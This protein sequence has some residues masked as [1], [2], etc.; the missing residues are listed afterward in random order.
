LWYRSNECFYAAT[1]QLANCTTLAACTAQRS[2]ITT[3]VITTASSVCASCSF[4]AAGSG[5]T[6]TAYAHQNHKATATA[7]DPVVDE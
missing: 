7:F 5:Q 2:S 1:R 4:T 6:T 3:R